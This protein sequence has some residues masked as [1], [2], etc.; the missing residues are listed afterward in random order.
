MGENHFAAL[1]TA[2][3]GVTLLMAAIGYLILQWLIASTGGD[4][5]ALK[6]ATALITCPVL[7]AL[8]GRGAR[9]N[10]FLIDES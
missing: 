7:F 5:S 3:Y 6:R 10:T 1:P 2:L 4:Q 8:E 9:S